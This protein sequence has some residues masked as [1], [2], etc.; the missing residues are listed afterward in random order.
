M[1]KVTKRKDTGYQVI[2]GYAGSRRVRASLQT[3]N[4]AAAVRLRD[5]IEL[6]LAEGKRSG[7]WQELESSLPRTAFEKFA[8]L[9]GYKDKSSQSALT[10]TDL[11]RSFVTHGKQLI[12]RHRLREST[13]RRYEYTLRAFGDFLAQE[14]IAHLERI[15]RPVVEQFKAWRFDQ[16]TAKKH[17][18]GGGSLDLDVAVLHRVFAHAVEREL[19]ARNPV[20]LEG[21]PGARPE[22]GAQPF[23]AKELAKLREHA[24]EDRL[25]FLLLRHTGLRGGDAVALTWAE[26]DLKGKRIDR[27]TEKRLKRVIVPLHPELQFA[28][29]AELEER[30]PQP[31]EVVLLNPATGQPLTRPRLYT[32]MRA[33]GKRAKVLNAHPHRFRDTMAVDMLLRGCSAYDVAK[34]LGDT[35]ATVEAHYAPY[36]PELQE[37]VRRFIEGPGGLEDEELVT[38]WSRSPKS[39]RVVQ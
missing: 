20:K 35:V 31:N 1:L 7:L 13:L 15:G 11:T 12:A 5:K 38:L 27:V 24:D 22:R 10:W 17:S 19:V 26:V 28:L 3:K 18:R 8:G 14:D 30:K 29:E 32:R 25:I 36:V 6:A 23:T 33:L 4:R 34:V 16:I 37:R 21:K 9:V 2:D 39:K